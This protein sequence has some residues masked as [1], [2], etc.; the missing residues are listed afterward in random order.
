MRSP[1]AVTPP[2]TAHWQALGTSAVLVVADGRELEPARRIVE[3]E[4]AALDRACSRFRDDSDL[5]RVNSAAGRVVEVDRLLVEAVDVALRAARLTDGDVDPTVGVALELAGY[6]RDFS[7]L[8]KMGPPTPAPQLSLEAGRRARQIE[9]SAPQGSPPR[10]T[11]LIRVRPGWQAIELDRERS[12]IRVPAAVKLDLGATA[13]AWAAD[14]AARAVYEA[15]RCGVLVSLGGDMAT[16]GPSPS[17]GWIV[18]VTEDHRDGLGA[19][20]QRI[21]IHSGGL[22][23]SSTAARRWRHRGRTMHHI[24]DPA[25]GCPAIGRFRT[26]TV[27][28]ASCADANIASTGAL[29]R[30]DD[31]PRWLA[32][33]GVPARLVGSDGEVLAIG[34]WPDPDGTTSTVCSAAT[35]EDSR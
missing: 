23:T 1:L 17:D 27:A 34:N 2:A 31:A 3:H 13:K 12:T 35:S 9:A 4:L 10:V 32:E 11:P 15:T 5:A 19:P 24:I 21:A 25:T 16:A 8:E 29:L 18:Y 28:A 6:D 30:G 20:G 7:L 33:L 22:A 26:A 14:R